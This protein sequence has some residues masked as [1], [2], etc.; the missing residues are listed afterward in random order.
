MGEPR[1]FRWRARCGRRGRASALHVRQLALPAAWAWDVLPPPKPARTRSTPAG[2]LSMKARVKPNKQSLEPRKE[3]A[4]T[5][6]IPTGDTSR[7]PPGAVPHIKLML[8]YGATGLW[9]QEGALVGPVDCRSRLAR[10]TRRPSALVR[11]V[12]DDAEPGL[13][14]GQRVRIG[15]RRGWLRGRGTQAVAPVVYGARQRVAR[16]L[17]LVA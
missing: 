6:R 2:W 9:C 17:R 16:R 7:L 3:S 11:C 8:D 14:A 12:R 1:T 5:E 13:P 4:A 15:G 10:D